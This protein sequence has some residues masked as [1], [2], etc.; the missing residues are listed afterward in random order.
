MLREWNHHELD[1]F[2]VHGDHRHVRHYANDVDPRRIAIGVQLHSFRHHR[3]VG[4]PRKVTTSEC[5]V[6]QRGLWRSGGVAGVEEASGDGAHMKKLEITWR[7]DG[8]TGPRQ[9]AASFVGL[10]A[11]PDSNR[12]AGATR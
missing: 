9:R 4:A 11:D 3:R 10:V 6:D 8:Q 1:D 12:R 7:Y 2:R 5:A